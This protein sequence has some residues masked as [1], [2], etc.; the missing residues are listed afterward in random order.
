MGQDGCG[1]GLTP[2][3]RQTRDRTGQTWIR[4]DMGQTWGRTGQTRDRMDTGQEGHRTG[5]TPDRTDTGQEGHGTGR[6]RDRT[7]TRQDGHGTGGTR[8][9]T[10]QR[11]GAGRA[12]GTQVGSDLGPPRAP[13]PRVGLVPTPP[14]PAHCRRPAPLLKPGLPLSMVGIPG[15]PG[16]WRLW[17][18]PPHHCPAPS[19]PVSKVLG[20]R[21]YSCGR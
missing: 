1:A 8:G 14:P 4:T 21:G 18:D 7:D 20:S 16:L 2:D 9:R 15:L 11:T 19:L 5:R 17:G 13:S 6:T 12:A 3:M 10:G